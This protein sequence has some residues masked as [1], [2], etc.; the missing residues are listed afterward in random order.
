M[1]KVTKVTESETTMSNN[2]EVKNV[3]I[4]HSVTSA[5]R[6]KLAIYISDIANNIS[7]IDEVREAQDYALLGKLTA[8][9]EGAI[10]FDTSFLPD[11]KVVPLKEKS[12]EK[13]F[14]AY[15]HGDVRDMRIIKKVL[16]RCLDLEHDAHAMRVNKEDKNDPRR[17]WSVRDVTKAAAHKIVEMNPTLFTSV[18]FSDMNR[19]SSGQK[20]E[21]TLP[22]TQHVPFEVETQETEN[23]A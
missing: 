5:Q 23:E 18:T 6:R 7:H 12:D 8:M 22:E 17:H 9:M 11:I 21:T 15:F 3:T 13:T 4:K 10:P 20:A 19:E 2:Q 1:H 16:R 14:T